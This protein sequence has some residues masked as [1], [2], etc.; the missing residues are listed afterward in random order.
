MMGDTYPGPCVGCGATNYPLSM[1]GPSVCPACDVYPPE[2]R[3]QQIAY[4]RDQIVKA[5][6]SYLD[7]VE[8]WLADP[9]DA[10]ETSGRMDQA[11]QVLRLLLPPRTTP[12]RD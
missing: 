11:D 8:A 12:K 5:A 9:I 1:G 3:V 10:P 7:A 4:E 2:K 6:W